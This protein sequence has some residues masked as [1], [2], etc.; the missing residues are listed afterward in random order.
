MKLSDV[1]TQKDLDAFMDEIEIVED[2]VYDISEKEFIEFV[3][4]N[5]TNEF[6]N[7]KEIIEFI[8]KYPDCVQACA[9]DTET[10][11]LISSMP[12]QIPEED[13]IGSGFNYGSTNVIKNCPKQILILA[14]ND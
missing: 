14:E 9:C 8:N 11:I 5:E 2:G 7:L 3:Y 1:K 6:I 4:D 12:K 10:T 13:V